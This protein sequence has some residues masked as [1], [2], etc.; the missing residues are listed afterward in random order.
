MCLV[1]NEISN[2]SDK[3]CKIPHRP[4]IVKIAHF[5]QRRVFVHFWLR[6]VSIDC[7]FH[8]FAIVFLIKTVHG[9]PKTFSS[10]ARERQ[11]SLA[12]MG[13]RY[14]FRNKVPFHW[15][16]HIC[17]TISHPFVDDVTFLVVVFIE[18]HIRTVLVLIKLN[19]R[20]HCGCVAVP[21]NWS[22]DIIS[23]FFAKGVGSRTCFF[24]PVYYRFFNHS[25]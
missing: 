12:L 20:L 24:G 4:P 2:R 7:C 11:I 15:W 25:I 3:K 18:V 13:L 14:L 22:F 23:S 19:L 21:L 17:P 5:L 10:D 6:H 9:T 16:R 8:T 1:G